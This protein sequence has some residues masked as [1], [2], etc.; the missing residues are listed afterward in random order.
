LKPLE[1]NDCKGPKAF[2]DYFE[3]RK[4]LIGSKS[5]V[6]K[7]IL[8]QFGKETYVAAGSLLYTLMETIGVSLDTELQMFR[9]RK[10]IWSEKALLTTNNFITSCDVSALFKGNE[11]P[12]FCAEFFL[13]GKE[14]HVLISSDDRGNGFSVIRRQNAASILD[15]SKVVNHPLVMFAHADG[16]VMKVKQSATSDDIQKLIELSRI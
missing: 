2:Q 3:A 12:L 14:C 5:P 7:V 11:Q 8:Q 10:Q 1:I 16:F 13:R 15:F 6:E 9:E 4:S